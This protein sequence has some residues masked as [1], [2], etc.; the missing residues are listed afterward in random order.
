MTASVP[1]AFENIEYLLGV[2]PVIVIGWVLIHKGARRS[3]ILSRIII[4][5]L[6][7][8]ALSGPYNPVTVTEIN[9]TPTIAVLS[10]ETESMDIFESGTAQGIFDKLQDT[11]PA[12]MEKMGGLRSDIG[13]EILASSTGDDHIIVVSD[14]NNNFGS[15]LAE[16][17]DF[18]SGTGTVVYAVTQAPKENDLSVEITG[19]RT[20]VLGNENLVGVEVRQAESNT[21]YK[22][23]I[24]V[25]GSPVSSQ[26]VTQTN[27]IKIVGFSSTFQSLGPHLITARIYSGNDMRA[28]NNVFNKTIYVVPKPRILLV[29]P[30][31]DSPL[32]K[33]LRNLYETNTFSSLDDANLTDYKAVVLDNINDGRLSASSIG[34]LREYTAGGGGLLVVGGDN[35]YDYGDYLDSSIEAILPVESYSSAYAG[36]VNVVLVLD[37]SGSISAHEA[38]DDE[39]AM[40]IKLLGD[41]GSDTNV[42]VVAY[43]G[44]AISVSN[45]VLP[46][47]SH[48]NRNALMERVSKLKTGY[49]GTSMD[50]GIITAARML[51]NTSGQKYMLVFSDGAVKDSFED[52]KI[53]ILSMDTTDTEMIFVMIKTNVVK[54]REVKTDNN[55]GDYLLE[56]LADQAGGDFIQLEVDQRLDL[57]FGQEA[58]DLPEDG[59]DAYAIV[60]LDEE[61]FITR[62]LNISGSISGYNDVT[63]KVGARRLVTTSMG[64]PVVTVWEFGLGRVVSL[65]SDNGYQ[66]AGVLY[67]GENARLLPSMINWAV[68]DPRPEDGI[69]VYSGDMNLGSPG[70]VIIWSDEMPAVVFGGQDVPVSQT[71][72]RT[73]EGV[74]EPDHIGLFNLEVSAGGV[75]LED[76]AAVNYP[77][78]YRDVGN[79]PE[80]LEAVKRSGGG[81]YNV[82]QAGSLLFSD[83]RKNSIMTSEEHVS[84][85]WVFLITALLVFLG[86]VIMRRAKGIIDIKTRRKGRER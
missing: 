80:F 48:A 13:D 65:S 69:V 67:S 56:V 3:L 83:I 32:Y 6:L 18:V 30:D 21:T 52:S 37:I 38:L 8:V 24:E 51:D 72:E 29:S 1:I 70:T 42:G 25:D 50:E 68:G 44:D 64:K 2:L 58:P 12:R 71:G 19:A 39:K 40:A 77:L 84:L 85:G 14:G 54:E 33:V 17:I 4:V 66:W 78:E 49:G 74:M 28:G 46:M 63:Q 76:T 31:A 36:S 73:Y 82:D 35:S 55:R 62:Y 10:D 11:T 53:E 16:T 20:A 60:R 57:T 7:V 79:D 45:G 47:S 43:G 5:S 15:D 22:L 61:H 81:V 59:L 26:T 75:T 34:K 41:M 23:S 86:E 9:E 27:P